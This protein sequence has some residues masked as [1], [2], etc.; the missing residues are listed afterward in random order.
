MSIYTRRGD[1]GLTTLYKAKSKVSKASQRIKAYG[2]LDELNSSLGL[3]IS[4]LTP[5]VKE[6]KKTINKLQEH[7]HEIASELAT[8]P[9]FTPPFL[10]N[11]EK[12]KYL[13]NIIDH[14]EAK[15]PPLSNFIFPGGGKAG[16][17][18][19]VS[20]SI[21]RR[22]EREVV[23]LSKKEKVNPQLIAYLNRLSDTLFV[24]ARAINQ[25]EGKKEIIWKGKN[26]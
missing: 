8:H 17:A 9:R 23:R 11:Q 5:E 22:T 25:A 6:F 26:W 24:L 3:A 21:A 12:V 19:H 1:R 7:L 2:T 18:L 14:Y 4:L 10:V 13:E 15:L 20:R 16:S